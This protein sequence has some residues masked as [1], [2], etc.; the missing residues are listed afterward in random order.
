MEDRDCQRRN[1]SSPSANPTQI[2]RYSGPPPRLCRLF[3]VFFSAPVFSASL[4]AQ[5][6][7]TTVKTD[8]TK[9]DVVELSP[10]TVSTTQDRGYTAQNSLGGSRLTANL[11]DV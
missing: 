11:K 8:A 2:M 3:V 9:E 7:S 1:A 6:A 10:F 5:A 4:L